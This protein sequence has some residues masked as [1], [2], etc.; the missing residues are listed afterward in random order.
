MH[1]HPEVPDTTLLITCDTC[2]M[3][4]TDACSDCLVT[5]LCGEPEPDAVIFDF[6]ELR[7]LAVLAKAGLVPRLRHQRS[8]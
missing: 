5:A 1:I 6:E 7:T 8:A 2:V 3:R 4:N